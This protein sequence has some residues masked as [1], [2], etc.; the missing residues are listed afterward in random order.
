MNGSERSEFRWYICGTFVGAKRTFAHI[1]VNYILCPHCTTKISEETILANADC[2]GK[3]AMLC[4]ACSES[5][6]FRLR[7]ATLEHLNARYADLSPEGEPVRAYL[8]LIANDFA[9]AALLPLYEGCNTIGS[10]NGRGTS[11]TTPIHSSD[12]SLGRNHCQITIEPDGQ[13]IIQDL[14]SMTGT[15]V[16]GVEYLP[17]T[18][19]ELHSG[20]VI[21]LG[22][23]SL[24]YVTRSDYEATNP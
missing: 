1:S 17:D 9:Y 23:T 4:P 14:D 5:L 21:T 12:P 2:R 11:V 19:C 15:F 18:F 16:A 6:R 13:A 22:A 24:I 8:Q 7:G 20:D 3:V 10:Y